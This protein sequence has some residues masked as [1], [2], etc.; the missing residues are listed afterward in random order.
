[1]T[2]GTDF[3]VSMT[4]RT[5]S[6]EC[7]V[8]SYHAKANKICSYSRIFFFWGG[9]R[10]G[11]K[12]HKKLSG[13][14]QHTH[15]LTSLIRWHVSP[16]GDSHPPQQG[17]ESERGWVGLSFLYHLISRRSAVYLRCT[18]RRGW[19]VCVGLLVDSDCDSPLLGPQHPA[20]LWRIH[21]AVSVF[22][23]ST[24]QSCT[25]VPTCQE[26]RCCWVRLATSTLSALR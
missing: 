21:N 4:G 3:N 12:S 23:T 24:M 14:R 10:G 7:D 22:E 13:R 8:H 9:G 2:L 19:T 25:S 26:I 16:V 1:M 15:T 18:G 11:Q 5:I 17:G 20:M 6:F